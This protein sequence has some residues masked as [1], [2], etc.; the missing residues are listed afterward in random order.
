LIL[1]FEAIPDRQAF[2]VKE[3]QKSSINKVEIKDSQ[4]K[5]KKL[6]GK[7]IYIL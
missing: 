1:L 4:D 6:K 5:K 2:K 7:Y 3:E